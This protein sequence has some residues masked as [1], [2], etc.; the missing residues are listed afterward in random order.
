MTE[1]GLGPESCRSLPAEYLFDTPLAPALK[2]IMRVVTADNVL[3]LEERRAWERMKEKGEDMTVANCDRLLELPNEDTA[4]EVTDDDL[5][6]IRDQIRLE[7]NWSEMLDARLAQLDAQDT[8]SYGE[9]GGSEVEGNDPGFDSSQQNLDDVAE[10]Y[11]AISSA[12]GVLK[13]TISSSAVLP[14]LES[15]RYAEAEDEYQSA[16]TSLSRQLLST[17]MSLLN[18]VFH[19]SNEDDKRSSE[20]SEI[21]ER[22]RESMKTLIMAKLD[23]RIYELL[24][25]SNVM[26]AALPN[27][28]VE[29]DVSG[30][31]DKL[32]A[33]LDN[34]ADCFVSNKDDSDLD[35]QLA[36]LTNFVDTKRQILDHLLEQY[37]RQMVFLDLSSTDELLYEELSQLLTQTRELFQK[38][39]S[40]KAT[41]QRSLDVAC[42]FA[43]P[44]APKDSSADFH[45]LLDAIKGLV[46]AEIPP[47]I[48]LEAVKDQ[49]RSTKTA[50]AED[51]EVLQELEA[52]WQRKD[53]KCASNE[54]AWDDELK[55]F[56]SGLLRVGEIAVEESRTLEDPQ[57]AID[58]HR[59]QGQYQMASKCV[60]HADEV[61]SR[62]SRPSATE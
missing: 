4:E 10:T 58:L 37:S 33:A 61:N 47:L 21:K 31:V 36:R 11:S 16:L 5:A 15:Q 51:V 53:S 46:I 14:L 24:K 8:L 27:S 2:G 44:P 12:S 43:N 50:T 19:P 41:I 52:E 54:K 29:C 17:R 55:T 34:A 30:A 57:A 9:D 23:L 26:D 20:K 49:S 62:A 22:Y 59:L 28:S 3:E 60:L 42:A 56:G 25:D 35:L 7:E 18:T 6:F 38:L 1:L 40:G 39:A 32:K 13:E 48:P 45:E